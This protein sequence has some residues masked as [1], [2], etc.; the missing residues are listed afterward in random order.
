MNNEF[1]ISEKTDIKLQPSRSGII[2][3]TSLNLKQRIWEEM[4]LNHMHCVVWLSLFKRSLI[5]ENNIRFPDHVAE[6]LFWLFDIICATGN[7]IKID[8]PVYIWRQ[9]NT[10]ASHE[11]SRLKKNVE[12]IVALS[13][14]L[15]RKLNELISD[16]PMFINI[17]ISRILRGPIDCYILPFFTKDF[18]YT[19]NM[20]DEAISSTFDKDSRFVISMI[21]NYA[22]ERFTIYKLQAENIKLISTLKNLKSAV[23]TTIPF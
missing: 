5:V 14:Y 2:G 9:V 23:N 3:K 8:K 12:A 7:I 21:Q 1:G 22:I 16:D 4:V 10:S 13:K 19:L 20:I 15:D 11:I 17:V 18:N 6:D